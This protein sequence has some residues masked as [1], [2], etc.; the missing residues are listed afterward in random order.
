MQSLACA[1]RSF[2][3]RPYSAE[4][5]AQRTERRVPAWR[6]CQPRSTPYPQEGPGWRGVLHV[7]LTL[8]SGHRAANFWLSRNFSI[9]RIFL[10]VVWELPLLRLTWACGVSVYFFESRGLSVV[11][12]MDGWLG[13]GV[14]PISTLKPQQNQVS[15]LSSGRLENASLHSQ[16]PIDSFPRLCWCSCCQSRSSP[17]VAGLGWA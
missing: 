1:S 15:Y 7:P 9:S 17:S 5:R 10:R 6:L 12:L 2:K 16:S 13:W 8:T 14:W 4:G 11:L 3:V